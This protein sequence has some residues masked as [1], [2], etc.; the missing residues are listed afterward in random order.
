MKTLFLS[1]FVLSFGASQC[2]EQNAVSQ[3][4]V[5]KVSR[6][7]QEHVR[8]TRD[9]LVIY[10][11]NNIAGNKPVKQSRKIEPE[12]WTRLINA[13]GK[14]NLKEIPALPSPTMERAH[15]AALHSTLTITTED[16]NS[17]AHGYDDESPHKILQPLLQTIREIAGPA[18]KP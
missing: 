17:Y 11:E 6:G 10:I 1:F 3:I 2:Q 14:Q 12:E 8:I 18:K 9:S 15:D 16:N 4:E 13:L 5:N 7:Y